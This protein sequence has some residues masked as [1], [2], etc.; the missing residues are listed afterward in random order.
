MSTLKSTVIVPVDETRALAAPW[1]ALIE[2]TKPGITRMV[3]LTAAVGYLVVALATPRPWLDLA[4]PLLATA[5]GTALAAAGANALNMWLEAPRDRRM[6]R[7]AARPIPSGRLRSGSVLVW[8]TL[9][10][11]LGVATLAAST[12]PAPALLALLSA[13][14]YLFVYTPLKPVT[15]WCTVVGAIPGALPTLIGAAAASDRF[16]AERMLEPAG[17]A[18]FA[19]LA[20]WQLP[21]FYALA[22]MYRHD[23]AAGGMRMLTVVE[24]T[25]RIA[26]RATVATA[27][28]FLPAALAPALFSP[29]LGI[30]YFVIAALTGIAFLALTVRLALA[31][32]DAA[33]R[34]V[35]FASIIHLPVLLLAMV[36]ETSLRAAL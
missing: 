4:A 17:L 35:F 7:T 13:A 29:V 18:L 25:G 12:G 34:R 3:A 5:I 36:A 30:P 2:A 23:Y 32:S 33:A 6:R 11:L 26:R 9:L 16:A 31:P 27:A 22:W 10:V 19:L 15:S 1:R 21:H 8:G 20:V 14:L 24:P 28:L